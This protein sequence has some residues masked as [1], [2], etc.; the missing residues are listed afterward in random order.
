MIDGT[1]KCAG[2]LTGMC[3]WSWPN[4]NSEAP[5][6]NDRVFIKASMQLNA[7]RYVVLQSTEIFSRLLILTLYPVLCMYISHD[8][9]V[10]VWCPVYC[11][12]MF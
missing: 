6:R 9:E 5:T 2:Q 7:C 3:C 11:D 8:S 10:P 12:A 4:L 1:S